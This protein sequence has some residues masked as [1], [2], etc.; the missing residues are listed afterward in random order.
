MIL[1]CGLFVALAFTLPNEP[2]WMLPVTAM[3]ALPV[4]R[5]F[6]AGGGV[7]PPVQWVGLAIVAGLLTYRSLLRDGL[8]PATTGGQIP[9]R[10]A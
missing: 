8:A 5:M 10:A 7:I 2:D 6:T 4:V 9:S 1:V 3:I